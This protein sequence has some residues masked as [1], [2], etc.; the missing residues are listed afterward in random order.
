MAGFF[1]ELA[2]DCIEKR[3][4]YDIKIAED[5]TIVMIDGRSF[6]KKV[7]KKFK[8]PFDDDFINAMNETAM[9]VMKYTSCCRL[10]YV[11]SDEISFV[12]T[13]VDKVKKDGSSSDFFGNRVC[14]LQ[15]IISSMATGFFNRYMMMHHRDEFTDADFD[16]SDAQI[17]E[18]DAK[19]W[20]VDTLEDVV[21]WLV[22]R[23]YDCIRNSKQQTAQTY[24][25]HSELVRKNVDE[26]IQM[27]YDN[28]GI[29][30]NAFDDGKKFGR[31]VYKV[32][33]LKDIHYCDYITG[34]SKTEQKL[35]NV[36]TVVPGYELKYRENRERLI[37]ES[38]VP[39]NSNKL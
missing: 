30:W 25:K 11:Q 2:K 3:S 12:L 16:I 14:K 32:P 22:Y 28:N 38:G 37:N 8:L 26:Q 39:D 19:A 13:S 33:T 34:K 18:F 27:V 15:S 36:V 24:I 10:A 20:G 9:F 21:N 23:Q 29:D 5:Y 7:K 17:F 6:S 31:F 4:R 1:N 35:C